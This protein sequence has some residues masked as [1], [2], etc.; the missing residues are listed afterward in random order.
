MKSSS[1]AKEKARSV[2]LLSFGDVVT[3]LITFF[4]ITIALNKGMITQSQKWAEEQL[5]QSYHRLKVREA[6]LQFLQVK[7]NSL[8]VEILIEDAHGFESG[9]FYPSKA[10]IEELKILA[11]TLETLPIFDMDE[12]RMPAY[13]K[14]IVKRDRLQ[15]R[16]DVNI[17][18]HTDN[19]PIDPHSYLRN[20]WFLSTMRA[21]QVMSLLQQESRLDPAIFAVA[22]YGEFR[23]K[24]SNR[25]SAGKAQNRRIDIILTATFEKRFFDQDKGK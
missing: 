13:I 6:Q 18:G 7:R 23:P 14:R 1:Y 2:W 10:L 25:S 12:S 4:I 8:G 3:L 5:D 21:Q 22:G 20:N 24:V 19:D 16:V 11:Q 15:W 9:G 17:A